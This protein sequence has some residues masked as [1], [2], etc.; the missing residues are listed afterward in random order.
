MT[1][2]FLASFRALVSK[3]LY[4]YSLFA[5]KSEKAAMGI[6]LLKGSNDGDNLTPK[7]G[8]SHRN[9][10]RGRKGSLPQGVFILRE[11]FSRSVFLEKTARTK[12]GRC[13]WELIFLR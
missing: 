10:Q 4:L 12:R 3:A 11:S 2:F 7:S 6:Y 8:K 13:P 5:R 1:L 9:V